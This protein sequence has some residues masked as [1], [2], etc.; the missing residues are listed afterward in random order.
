MRIAP[1]TLGAL[2]IPGPRTPCARTGPGVPGP[3]A[4]YAPTVSRNLAVRYAAWLDANR[5]G[6]LVL[7]VLVAGL[8]GLLASRLP[9]RSDLTSLLPGSKSS[10]IAL[11]QLKRRAQAFATINVVV[12]SED[13]ALRAQA[14]AAL[15]ERLA[16]IG[17][18]LVTQYSPDDGPARR[19]AW[20]HRFLFAD[21]ADLEAA[22]DALRDRLERG[23]L[24]SNPLYIDLGD[25]PATTAPDRLDELEAK[26][27]DAERDAIQPPPRTSAD[28]TVQLLV[29][30]TSFGATDQVKGRR[31]LA[32]IDTAI[33]QVKKLV[34]P[35]VR[36]GLTGNAVFGVYE[37]DSALAGM[38]WSAGLTLLLCAIALV[39]YY[40]SGRLVLAMLWALAVG[41]AATFAV[42]YLLIGHLD[43]MSAFLAAIVIGNGLN[44]GLILVA[45][46]LEEIRGGTAPVAAVGPAMVGALPGT[47]AATATAAIAYGSLIVTDFRGFRYF[48]AIGGVGMA[49]TW[50]TTFTVLPAALFVLARRGRI[51]QTKPPA[52]G[53]ILGRLMPR[54]L[55]LVI[56]I[57]G[58]VTALAVAV[59][60]R[61]VISDPFTRDW[62]DLQ[63]TT[64]DIA[65]AR[66]VDFRI[67]AALDTRGL[68]GAQ[69]YQVVIAVERA[70]Q[71]APLVAQI[72]ADE[73]ARPPA[74][75]WLTD[76][77]S[78]D[79][80]LPPDQDRKLAVL[81]DIRRSIDDPALQAS[82]DD[83]ERT[84]LAKLRPP[85]DLARLD[86]AV[87][88]R[89][90]AWP[91]IEKDGA[92]GRLIVLRGARTL[93]SFNVS[94]RLRFAAEVRRLR[95]PPDAVVA[96][97]ALVV[98]DIIKTM[99]HDA[100]R[101][102]VVALLGST[103]AVFLVLGLRRHGLVTVGC[104]LAGV[105]VMI[106][107]CAL[108]GL[109]VH[110]LDLIAL[111][112][113]I[114][115][116]IDY[117]VN[118]AARDREEGEKGPAHLLATT[119]GAVLMCSY[120]TAVGYGTLM[121]SANGGIRAFGL[122][123]LLGELSCIAMA[124]LVAPAL[125]AVLRR[126][127]G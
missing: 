64:D 101:M 63:S 93:N 85:D 112:I 42:A 12:E 123:A 81:A 16:A 33:R 127:H 15:S 1:P 68:L 122:A 78:L 5:V 11:G 22:R 32:K 46:Y 20:D 28:G 34:G 75:R 35:K 52:I 36:F 103:L 124:L 37:H 95:L 125:L 61:Y 118:L 62:R 106:A 57:G 8:S 29:V 13:P 19:Y 18:E 110:F 25:D 30:Q 80:L 47:L 102:V 44:A 23:K 59:T 107:A 90:L 3:G 48:G 109:R 98:A 79:D 84:K 71:A 26:L 82:L 40:R 51:R 87:V 27:A 43:M 6:L 58:V 69:A 39:W 108:V 49:L 50:L 70:E 121:L 21:L 77:R 88:P 94:D 92:R 17:P 120:T 9:V 38:K 55:D 99:E 60:T 66:R 104:G 41:V 115:I 116:G 74:Q 14:G 105:V 72:R 56:W 97:E 100:P 83:D 67:R 119:G 31:L 73:A 7:S 24:A 53:A 2:R 89:A 96:G 114:G 126:R 86:D 10:V 113:T 54:R 45:R 65:R 76:V 4:V 117:A 91:F 111:P